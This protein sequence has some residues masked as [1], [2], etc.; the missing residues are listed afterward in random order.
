[1]TVGRWG[2]GIAGKSND[3]RQKANPVKICRE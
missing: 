1:M 2:K 3:R